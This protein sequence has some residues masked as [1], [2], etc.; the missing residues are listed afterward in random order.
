M[1]R[2][3]VVPAL[4]RMMSEATLEFWLERMLIIE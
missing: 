1:E 4:I 2:T 3:A